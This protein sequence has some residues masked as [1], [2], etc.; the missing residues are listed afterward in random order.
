MC[1]IF[2]RSRF[3][4]PSLVLFL[5]STGTL[6]VRSKLMIMLISDMAEGGAVTEAHLHQESLFI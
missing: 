3:R 4:F 1:R 5:F 2:L 6:G